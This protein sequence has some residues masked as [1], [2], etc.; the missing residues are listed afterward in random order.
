VC[1]GEGVVAQE[2]Q[3]RTASPK[4]FY[5]EKTR[6]DYDCLLNESKVAYRN[7]VAIICLRIS[8]AFSLL[9]PVPQV[10]KFPGS[11]SLFLH[12]GA[13]N[14]SEVTESNDE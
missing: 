13:E 7:K 10:C 12:P 14:P 11:T 5:A 9:D 1:G 4:T 8:I 2:R 6:S 3:H